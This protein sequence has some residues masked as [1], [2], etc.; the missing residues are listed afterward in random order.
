M[1]IRNCIQFTQCLLYFVRKYVVPKGEVVICGKCK[2]LNKITKN[3]RISLKFK[4]LLIFVSLYSLQCKIGGTCCLKS[5][6]IRK[7][8][9]EILYAKI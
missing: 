3:Y 2:N 6:I 5:V 1:L 9:R 7:D 8:Q 4:I